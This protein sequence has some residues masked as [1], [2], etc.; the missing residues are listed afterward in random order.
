MFN[1][2][3]RDL[4]IESGKCRSLGFT[5]IEALVA[6]LVLS[7]G[8]LGI[9]AMQLKATQSSHLAYNRSLA[10]L[11]AQDAVE[12]LWA[13]FGNPVTA[14]SNS[15]DCPSPDVVTTEWRNNWSSLLPLLPESEQASVAADPDGSGDICK[16]LITIAWSDE[17]F[18]DE[19]VSNLVYVV[20]LPG[21]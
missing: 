17:R 14:G 2:L 18:S 6:I 1:N 21:N 15:G 16:Y 4:K 11:A 19:N 5:L 8:L 20:K 12:R 13:E 9:A 3:S 7:V 10:T